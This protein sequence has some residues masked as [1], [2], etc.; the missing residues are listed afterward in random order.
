MGLCLWDL[1]EHAVT[2]A[3][4]HPN[5][6]RG[7][8]DVT[9]SKTNCSYSRPRNQQGC[10]EEH[11]SFIALASVADAAGVLGDAILMGPTCKSGNV[12]DWDRPK[13]TPSLSLEKPP[14]AANSRRTDGLIS[15]C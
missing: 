4:R 15:P 5:A 12:R 9:C 6:F 3:P 13:G 14:A 7:R 2:G 11:D 10:S 8:H 1:T